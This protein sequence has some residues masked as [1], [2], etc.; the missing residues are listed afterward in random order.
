MNEIIHDED[1]I[2][3]KIDSMF[4]GDTININDFTIVYGRVGIQVYSG[5]NLLEIFC[6]I[7]CSME[8][9]NFIFNV[10]I[11]EHLCRKELR[12]KFF[13]ELSARMIHGVIYHLEWYDDIGD[14][15]RDSG[16]CT[17]HWEPMPRSI[18]DDWCNKNGITFEELFK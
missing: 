6:G 8:A 2:Y 11:K 15:I 7:G 10:N 4:I 13:N 5:E 14:T 16:S 3:K 18:A 17:S 9:A 1:T 12:Q